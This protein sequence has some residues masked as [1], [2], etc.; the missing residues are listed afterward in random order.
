MLQVPK[1]FT[2]DLMH[3][4]FINLGELLIPLWCGAI[5]CDATDNKATW[6][7]ATLVGQTWI[8]H[9]K[10]IAATTKYF[11]SLFHHPP[12]NPTEKISSGF[13]ATEYYLYLFGLGPAFF[14]MILPR[15]YWRNFC[16]L[17]YGFRIIMQR[18]VVGYQLQEGYIA[19][20]SFIEEYENLYYQ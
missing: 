10:L 9:G 3:L 12:Q 7:W 5:Q 14:R 11:P 1:C 19:L 4:G 18:K 16:K 8:K 2:V 6:D 15:K 13:K 17:V 20:T